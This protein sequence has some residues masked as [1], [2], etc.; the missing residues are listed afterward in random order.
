MKI[1]FISERF[2]WP[3]EDGGNLR[4]FHV[5]NAICKEHEVTLLSHTPKENVIEAIRELEKICH[6]RTVAAPSL[7]KTAAQVLMQ[8]WRWKEPL[9]V[10]KNWSSAL[11][12]ESQKLLKTKTFDVVHFN[13]LDTAAF[14][15][16]LNCSTSVFDSHNCISAMADQLASNRSSGLRKLLYRRESKALAA[17]EKEVC[18][19]CDIVLACSQQD[20]DSFLRLSPAAKIHVVPNG[21][22]IGTARSNFLETSDRNTKVSKIVFVGAMDYSPNVVGAEWFCNQVL[23]IIRQ[24]H[25]R[26][27]FQ[28]VGRNPTNRVLGLHDVSGSA[29]EQVGVEV[30]GRV[31]SVTSYL[32][33]AAV[34]VVPLLD[35][36]GTRLK[37]LEAFAARRPVVSTAKGAEGIDAQHEREILIADEP[38]EFAVSVLRLLSSPAEAMRIGNAGYRLAKQR[39]DWSSIQHQILNLYETLDSTQRQKAIAPRILSISKTAKT[40]TVTN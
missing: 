40:Q 21:A 9:F 3:L 18:D 37:I 39:Y 15:E 26:V 14:S 33:N 12:K 22:V 1:L 27:L 32:D 2:P 24:R 7:L 34:V 13:H 23:P 35:G 5:L 38:T 20:R 29:G 36:G 19:R 25:S 30:T 6:V 8:P 31:G 17:K 11:F 16:D 28:I 10:L 4:T